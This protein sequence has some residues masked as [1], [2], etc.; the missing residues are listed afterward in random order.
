MDVDDEAAPGDAAAGY[1]GAPA[2]TAAESDDAGM[3]DIPPPPPPPAG[4]SER[5]ARVQLPEHHEDEGPTYYRLGVDYPIDL[6]DEEIHL[7]CARVKKLENLEGIGPKLKRLI[8]IAN[9]I[10]KIEN[11]D[12]NV[13]LD[14]L[15][16]Y[17]NLLKKIENISHLT[18]LTTLDLS[19]N[20]IRSS[21]SLASCPFA[22]LEKL[23]LSSNKITDIEGVFHLTSLKMLE[24]GSNRIRAVPPEIA[25]LVNLEQLWL[26]KNKMTSMALPPMPALR[27]LSM[28]NNRLEVWEPSFFQNASGLTHLYLG[29]NNLPDLPEE[30]AL[31]VNLVEVDLVRNVITRIKPV[32]EL[33]KLEE[34]WM[35]DNKIEDLAEVRN[36]AVFPALKTIYL[37]RNPMQSLGDKEAEKRYRDAIL[38]VVPNITQLDADMLNRKVSL[39]TNGSEQQVMGIRKA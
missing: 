7:Q 37:E 36:L 21:D 31:L 9:C 34:L 5:R 27:H 35:N 22:K 24:L 2:P 30:F 23:Y 18:N 11:L 19:F 16:L 17:Q 33:V 39:V 25:N 1:G 13:N 15:E 28:Q 4:P 8:L 38:E 6:N 12:T 20:K 29:H 3:E 26:G 14:H 10:E 32:P